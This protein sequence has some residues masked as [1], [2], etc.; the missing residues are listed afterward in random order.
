MKKK[1][2]A[3]SLTTLLLAVSLSACNSNTTN[4]IDNEQ[5]INSIDNSELVMDNTMDNEQLVVGNENE[6]INNKEELSTT[7][8]PLPTETPEVSSTPLPTE[9]ATTNT[10]DNESNIMDNSELVMENESNDNNNNDEELP[11]TNS[12]LP[13]AKPTA[14]PSP[15]PTVEP[16]PVVTPVPTELPTTNSPL[17]TEL[18]TVT[19][20]PTAAPTPVPTAVPVCSHATQKPE[21]KICGS[22]TGTFK[23]HITVGGCS[24]E[25]YEREIEFVCANCKE[26]YRVVNG[27]D[28]FNVTHNK[29]ER[30]GSY[31]S[32]CTTGGYFAGYE[33]DCGECNTDPRY[34]DEGG[35]GHNYKIIQ[36]EHVWHDGSELYPD[37]EAL[38][39]ISGWNE[40]HYKEE[41]SFCGDVTRDWWSTQHPNEVK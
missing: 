34:Y 40:W 32:T 31:I 21:D 3:I 22:Y 39:A 10:I 15:L 30:A 13:T 12:P 17:P 26:H 16:T 28:K 5:S 25:E 19:P 37:D 1:I 35:Y 38:A 7:H 27:V 2:L 20:Q 36:L 23:G 33:C 18:P 14:T 41:C 29:H 4:S 9:E 6:S 24:W 8:S 11:I